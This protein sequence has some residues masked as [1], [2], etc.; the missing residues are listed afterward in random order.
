MAIR[1]SFKND[2]MIIFAVKANHCKIS[3]SLAY[4]YKSSC[5][6]NAMSE[7]DRQTTKPNIEFLFYFI[8]LFIFVVCFTIMEKTF[9]QTSLSAL[10]SLNLQRK[11]E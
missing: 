3:W 6:K 11:R 4:T 10:N 7:R 8:L 5:L 1:H 2:K 9:L